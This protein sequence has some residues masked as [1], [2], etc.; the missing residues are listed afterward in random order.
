VEITIRASPIA[1]L[2]PTVSG[3]TV[4]PTIVARVHHICTAVLGSWCTTLATLL[5]VTIIGGIARWTFPVILRFY[6]CATIF[7]PWGGALMTIVISGEVEKVTL[8]TLPIGVGC[9][10]DPAVST[11]AGVSPHP[12]AFC[13]STR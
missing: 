4:I 12:F 1:K 6:V 3:V 7:G 10:T 13:L 8:R 9:I 11:P 2:M 5:V